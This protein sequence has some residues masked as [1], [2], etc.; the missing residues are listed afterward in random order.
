MSPIRERFATKVAWG[1]PPTHKP[2]LGRCLEWSGALDLDGYGRLAPTRPGAIKAHRLAYE[3]HYGKFD[4]KMWVLHKCDNRRCVR[5]SHLKLGTSLQNVQDRYLARRC[6]RGM[7]SGTAR[8]TNTMV[9]KV[10]RLLDSGMLQKDIAEK[11]DIARSHIS[12]ID[13]G[14]SWN[15]LT[16]RRVATFAA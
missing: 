1:N 14:E 6:A 4:P 8:L 16:G 3:L 15:H 11:M 5:P 7:R 13:R 2:H 12:R 9:L 10:V